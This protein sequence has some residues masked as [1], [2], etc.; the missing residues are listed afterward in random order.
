MVFGTELKC[1][2]CNPY[3]ESKS[4]SRHIPGFKPSVAKASALSLTL[5][6]S[7]S[8]PGVTVRGRRLCRAC[9]A[10]QTRLNKLA[11]V[12]EDEGAPYQRETLAVPRVCSL[13][14]ETRIFGSK[15]KKIDR[16]AIHASAVTDQPMGKR[17]DS[18]FSILMY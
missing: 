6:V 16:R 2:C 8:C 7:G 11:A 17:T 4:G 12:K 18:V 3:C 10:I 15:P 14:L 1:E 5:H 13:P 9:A